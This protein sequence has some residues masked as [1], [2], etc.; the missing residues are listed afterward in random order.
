MISF[1]LLCFRVD[2]PISYDPL[3]GK[4]FLR[5]DN[6]VC[7]L[8]YYSSTLF[9]YGTRSLTLCGMEC[10]VVMK[11]YV[12]VRKLQNSYRL[13]W[14][15]KKKHLVTMTL[16]QCPLNPYRLVSAWECSIGPI[17]KITDYIDGIFNDVMHFEA[18]FYFARRSSKHCNTNCHWY[19]S[20]LLKFLFH[21]LFYYWPCIRLYGV[22]NV[23]GTC[24]H[25]VDLETSHEVHWCTYV[26]IGDLAARVEKNA[27][28]IDHI[29]ELV[30]FSFVIFVD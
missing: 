9:A 2:Q 6:I 7:S 22:G 19:E 5:H 11:I 20:Y 16:K 12:I 24:R 21:Q 10:A 13:K 28:S 4:I 29:P 15:Q 30:D 18:I 8:N 25:F 26:Y 27:Q 17:R 14:R 3:C 23:S 1:N